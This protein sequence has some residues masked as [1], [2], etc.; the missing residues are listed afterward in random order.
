M[1][2]LYNRLSALCNQKGVTGAQMCR[3]CGVSKSLMSDLK[4]GR[5]DNIATDT[6]IKLA[7]YFNVSV[8]EILKGI[9]KEP[10]ISE[11]DE[12]MEY[13]EMLRSRPEC[14]V[15]LNTVK[16]A[17]KAEV[18]ENVRFISAMRQAKHTDD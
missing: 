14:R 9:K 10:T 12:L 5:R 11:D 2:E 16:G 4:Y 6:A 13:L 7:E 1:C 17:T 3:E 15:L 8:E 18:E